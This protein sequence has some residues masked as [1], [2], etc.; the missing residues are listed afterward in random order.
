[1]HVEQLVHRVFVFGLLLHPAQYLHIYTPP[2]FRLSKCCPVSPSLRPLLM[3]PLSNSRFVGYFFSP[4]AFCT[5]DLHHVSTAVFPWT[6]DPSLLEMCSQNHVLYKVLLLLALRIDRRV[7]RIGLV[8]AA[9]GKPGSGECRSEC[10]HRKLDFCQPSLIQST[11]PF[12]R[13]SVIARLSLRKCAQKRVCNVAFAESFRDVYRARGRTTC[14][15]TWRPAMVYMATIF[16]V[17]E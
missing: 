9:H 17:L 15:P 3:H 13:S 16:A 8:T 5:K 11:N 10:G 7:L 4:S 14:D 1:V 6:Y 2:C 12:S